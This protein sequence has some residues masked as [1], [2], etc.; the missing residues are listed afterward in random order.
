MTR[1]KAKGTKTLIVRVPAELHDMLRRLA[2]EMDV[3]ITHLI[4]QYLRYLRAKDHRERKKHTLSIHNA[5]ITAGKKTDFKLDTE[6]E[7]DELDA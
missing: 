1:I 4:L 2:V 6:E 7:E 5:N 3:T